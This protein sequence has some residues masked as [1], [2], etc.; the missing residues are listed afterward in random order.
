MKYSLKIACLTGLMIGGGLQ[1]MDVMHDLNS[2][3]DRAIANKNIQR[4]EQ[5]IR[6]GVDINAPDL[7]G[8]TP[9]MMAAF[10]GDEKICELLI[11]NHAIIET[12]NQTGSDALMIAARFGKTA[13]CKLLIAHGA[14]VY[15]ENYFRKNALVEAANAGHEETCRLLIKA[16][17]RPTDEEQHIARVY[18]NALRKSHPEIGRDERRLLVETTLKDFRQQKKPK[19]RAEIMK[20]QDGKLRDE[21]LEYLKT[22]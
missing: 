16:M 2:Q 12:R 6:Q 7:K 21:L 14:N 18:L 1:A 22:L 17:L 9:L 5:L 19:A 10:E 3:L 11:A 4:V 8:E 13:V 15:G 20:I